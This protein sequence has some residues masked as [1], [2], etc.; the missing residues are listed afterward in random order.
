LA[1]TASLSIEGGV[2]L[3]Q[4]PDSRR[5]LRRHALRPRCASTRKPSPF[6]PSATRGHGTNK[7]ADAQGHYVVQT[8]KVREVA[9]AVNSGINYIK[10]AATTTIRLAQIP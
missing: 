10:P 5:R 9:T 2:L 4:L 8:G 7:G 3:R 1:Q 6:K